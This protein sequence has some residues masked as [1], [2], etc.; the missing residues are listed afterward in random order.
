[1]KEYLGLERGVDYGWSRWGQEERDTERVGQGERV[2]TRVGEG[3]FAKHFLDNSGLGYCCGVGVWGLAVDFFGGGGGE[4]R[5]TNQAEHGGEG[6]MRVW[7][8]GLGRRGEGE[9]GWE[10]WGDHLRTNC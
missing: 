5:S 1:M 3:R 7:V 6:G 10:G 2:K 8:S 4:K 9:W